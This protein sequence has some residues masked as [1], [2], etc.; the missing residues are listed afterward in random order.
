MHLTNDSFPVFFRFF[1][2]FRGLQVVLDSDLA[3]FYH[4]ETKALNQ[5]TRRNLD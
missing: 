1:E 4:T 5:A 3:E 2:W